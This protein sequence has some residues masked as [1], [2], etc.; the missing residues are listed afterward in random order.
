MFADP[1][2]F[3]HPGSQ[4]SYL[5]LVATNFTKLKIILVCNAEEKNSAQ[6][7]KEL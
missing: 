4:I 6:F 5:F 3:T 2:I 7:F 1:V